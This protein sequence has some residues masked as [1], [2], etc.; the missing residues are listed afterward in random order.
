VKKG[1][2]YAVFLPVRVSK[3]WV[4]ISASRAVQDAV[5]SSASQQYERVPSLTT[6]KLRRKYA[7]NL[8]ARSPEIHTS[9]WLL[10]ENDFSPVE[11]SCITA[12]KGGRL[13]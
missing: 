9:P 3:E 12:G 8:L 11:N 4:F 1:G 6:A 7:K 5:A 2:T 13:Q 10:L